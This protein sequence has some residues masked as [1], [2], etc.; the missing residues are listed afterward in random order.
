MKP[1]GYIWLAKSE[2]ST[3]AECG[4]ELIRQHKTSNDP[5]LV[6]CPMHEAAPTM[7]QALKV[8]HLALRAKVNDDLDAYE[9]TKAAIQEA[10]K[11]IQ[12]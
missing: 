8:A 6:L 12:P 1:D 7:L 11:E 10:E 2:A 3:S 5:A 4:C 9:I